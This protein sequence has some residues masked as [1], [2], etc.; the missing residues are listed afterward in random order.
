MR[1]VKVTTVHQPDAGQFSNRHF[2]YP[3][4]LG[5]TDETTAREYAFKALDEGNL[6]TGLIRVAFPEGAGYSFR[7]VRMGLMGYNLTQTQDQPH[8]AQL[9]GPGLP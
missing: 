8:E 9:V 2:A 3:D 4:F 6:R 7:F 5:H 1:Y